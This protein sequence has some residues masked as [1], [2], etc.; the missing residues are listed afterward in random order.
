MQIRVHLQYLGHPI[1]NDALYLQSNVAKRSKMNT[2]A[3]LAAH[4]VSMTAEIPGKVDDRVRPDSS[5]VGS[6]EAREEAR[7]LL[8]NTGDC[9]QSPSTVEFRLI[10]KPTHQSHY[11]SL[12]RSAKDAYKQFDRSIDRSECDSLNTAQASHQSPQGNAVSQTGKSDIQLEEL[13]TNCLN[14]LQ[15]ETTSIKADFQVDPLCTHCPNLEPSG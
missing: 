10:S 6:G 4:L 2:S 5:T 1:G 11:Q 15:A 8:Q 12:N 14:H 9:K 7:S 13:G 3:D